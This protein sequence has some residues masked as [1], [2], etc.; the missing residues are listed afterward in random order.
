MAHLQKLKAKDLENEKVCEIMQHAAKGIYCEGIVED[1]GALQ[2]HSAHAATWRARSFRLFFSS[3]SP[4]CSHTSILHPGTCPQKAFNKISVLLCYYTDC[5][6][7]VDLQLLNE[8]LPLL[9]IHIRS[10]HRFEANGLIN[11]PLN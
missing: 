10:C 3:L 5:G 9:L 6:G 7:K 1:L 4:T 11:M 2:L 8:P